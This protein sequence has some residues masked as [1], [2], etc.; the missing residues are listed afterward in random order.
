[1]SMCS[2]VVWSANILG[3][4]LIFAGLKY[5]N[6]N[7]KFYAKINDKQHNKTFQTISKCVGTHAIYFI[8]WC[9]QQNMRAHYNLVCVCG[10]MQTKFGH[11]VH[12]LQKRQPKN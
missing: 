11:L 7:H 2:D 10:C 6:T 5:D 8:V 3:L 4:T 1:M 9:M 12:S